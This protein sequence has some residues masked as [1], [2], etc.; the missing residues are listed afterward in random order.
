MARVALINPP[1]QR[2]GA[3]TPHLGLA[4]LARA[5]GERGHAIDWLDLDLEKPLRGL[6]SFEQ[7]L[8]LTE[9][10]LAEC[11]PDVIGCTSMFNNS[12]FA[13]KIAETGRRTLPDAAIVAGGPHFGV[14]GERALRRNPALDHVVTGEA[15]KA[16]PDLVDALESGNRLDGVT[17]LV[18]R[19]EDEGN[20]SRPPTIRPDGPLI[21]LKAMSGNIWADLAGIVPL[22]RYVA[23]QPANGAARMTY[24]EA[25]RGCP[26]SC[27]FCATAPF[28]KNRY[29]TKPVETIVAEMEWLHAAH[30][31]G[32]FILVHDLLT[33]RRDFMSDLCDAIFDARLPVTWMANSRIDIDHGGLLPKF[34]AAGCTKLFFGIE[35]ASPEIQRFTTKR[36]DPETIGPTIGAL[37]R[38]GITS[39]CSFVFGFPE[40]SEAE[41]SR[42]VELAA[43]TKLLGAE[44]VQFHRLRLWPPAPI[45]ARSGEAHF[46]ED[47]LRI[48]WPFTRVEPGAI[49][50]IRADRDFFPGYYS[51]D[52]PCGTPRQLARAETFFLA[53]IATVPI[54]TAL[55]CRMLGERLIGVF[56]ALGEAG[57][58]DAGAAPDTL[59]DHW[60]GI[61][62]LFRALVA[63]A[64]AADDRHAS[65]IDALIDYELKRLAFVERSTAAADSMF[66]RLDLG[67]AD[68]RH[69]CDALTNGEP[70]DGGAP[71]G[72]TDILFRR[73]ETGEVEIFIREA[74]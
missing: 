64:K 5:L 68:L 17:N 47:S 43:Q 45:V 19:G 23:T 46:D 56:N 15:D 18:S 74:A 65:L 60:R 62:P 3:V 61:E 26:F 25:G 63:E 30:G 58:G 69:V 16:F 41:F 31:F 48:E 27:N 50:E 24:I 7:C 28:W 20:P 36:L 11:R 70:I 10:W 37:R 57:P 44:T 33:V 59:S 55:L 29:R 67:G 72:E 54:A 38:Q 1:L 14:L 34:R 35:S 42:T 49:E 12:L 53:A 39:T 73:D 9:A 6:T 52:S 4:V 40:E 13:E 22:E 2:S 51:L 8:A 32:H 66:V 21:D 71:R